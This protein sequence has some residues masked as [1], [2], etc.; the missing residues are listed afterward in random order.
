M[1]RDSGRASEVFV[2]AQ[3]LS[4]LANQ[5][6]LSIDV[7][8]PEV[9]AFL[10]AGK[11]FVEGKYANAVSINAFNDLDDDGFDEVAFAELGADALHNISLL[12]GSSIVS[13][14]KGY[15]VRGR[16]TSQP[17][18][19]PTDGALGLDL[20]YQGDL[21]VARATLLHRGTITGT[22]VVSGSNINGLATTSPIVGVGILHI[23]NVVGAGTIDLEI[24]QSS[25]DGGG[26]AYVPL[27]GFTAATA[28]GSERRPQSANTEAWKRVNITTFTGFTSVDIAVLWAK[29]TA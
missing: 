27:I 20:S 18:R 25:D 1:A 12:P 2:D 28:I 11:T 17:R 22:G 3:R 7:D 10:D 15:H 14:S 4:G 29:E 23:Y 13:G 9:S 8:T 26:D 21:A 19:S 24:Q 16:P 6:E 5:F